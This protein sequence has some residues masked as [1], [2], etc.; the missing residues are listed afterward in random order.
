MAQSDDTRLTVDGADSR[1]NG[2]D[3]LPEG[4]ARLVIRENGVTVTIEGDADEV[5]R[6]YHE[7][8]ANAL[9]STVDEFTASADEYPHPEFG[10]GLVS[11]DEFYADE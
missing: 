10:E 4:D 8:M 7:H 9:D 2:E 11:A 3:E 6:R 1:E 5:R